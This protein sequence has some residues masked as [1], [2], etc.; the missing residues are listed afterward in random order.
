MFPLFCDSP[1]ELHEII[2]SHLFHS[3]NSDND[4]RPHRY[5]ATQRR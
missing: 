5:P 1:G 2:F 4:N 3:E